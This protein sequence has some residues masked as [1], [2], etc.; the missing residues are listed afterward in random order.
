ME[1]SFRAGLFTYLLNLIK[2]NRG[3]SIS[4]MSQWQYT[5]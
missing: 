1:V 2:K 4:N 5:K 3:A